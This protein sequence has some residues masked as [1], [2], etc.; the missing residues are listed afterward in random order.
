[1]SSSEWIEELK[2]N[3]EGLIPVVAQDKNDGQLLMM[4]WMNRDALLQTLETSKAV[5]FSRSRQK[6]WCKGEESGHYQHVEEIR[7]DCDQDVILLTVSQDGGIA[8]HTGRKSCFYKKLIEEKWVDS[9]PV[10]K[11]PKEIYNK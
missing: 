5:Y 4:A 7:T 2:W 3:N 8:C 6:I 10:I 11:D 9:D 1:M